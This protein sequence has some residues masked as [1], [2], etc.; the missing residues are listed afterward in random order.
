MAG[1]ASGTI[2][3]ESKDG[4]IH[5]IELLA[6]EAGIGPGD[7]LEFNTA[8]NG[9]LRHNTAAGFVGPVLVALEKHWNDDDDDIAIDV[10]YASGDVMRVG[11]PQRGDVVYMWLASG[12]NASV[13]DLLSSDGDGA[14]AVNAAVDATDPTN[15]IVGVAME[16]VNA[17]AAISRI[18]V[19]II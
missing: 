17:T 9:A 10:D 1:T 16:A 8:A 11:I 5:T 19:R 18:R 13:L 2:L 6:K 14:L 7:L 3:L 12:E 4:N 15:S